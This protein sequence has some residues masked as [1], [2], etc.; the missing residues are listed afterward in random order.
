[1]SIRSIIT[2]L[3]LGTGGV[4]NC[5]MTRASNIRVPPPRQLHS[6]PIAVSGG[7]HTEKLIDSLKLPS[8]CTSASQAVHS[9]MQF[10]LLATHRTLHGAS[11]LVQAMSAWSVKAGCATSRHCRN[12]KVYGHTTTAMHKYRVH[13]L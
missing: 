11:R 6:T 10:T 7:G 4:V 1:M 3:R 12:A 13:P 2:V 5:Q 9:R 8:I